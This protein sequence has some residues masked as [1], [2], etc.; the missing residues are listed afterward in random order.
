MLKVRVCV[1]AA[2]LLSV[3]TTVKA[4]VWFVPLSALIAAAL[5]A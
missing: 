5:G 2:P 4:S 3:T 1:T